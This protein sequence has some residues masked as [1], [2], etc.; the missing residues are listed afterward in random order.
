M[1]L[2]R[3]IE[4]YLDRTGVAPSFA[5]LMAGLGLANTSGVHRLLTER[6]MAAKPSGSSLASV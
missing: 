5:E 1:T 2:L 6:A 4:R 3:D